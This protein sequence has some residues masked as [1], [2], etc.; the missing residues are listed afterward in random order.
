MSKIICPPNSSY[1][2]SPSNL[3]LSK[4][5]FE[6]RFDNKT[7]LRDLQEKEEDEDVKS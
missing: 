5:L 1:F 7:K 4:H 3:G 6:A 2:V